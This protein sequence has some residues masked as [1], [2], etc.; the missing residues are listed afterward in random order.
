M[1]KKKKKKK[2]NVQEGAVS[3]AKEK[4]ARDKGLF[5][6]QSGKGKL[7]RDSE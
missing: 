2:K 1:K 6:I 7:W 3:G 4:R 5:R